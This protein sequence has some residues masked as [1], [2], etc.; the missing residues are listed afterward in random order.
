MQVAEP[1]TRGFLKR[2]S[3]AP[4]GQKKKA[5]SA[6]RRPPFADQPHPPLHHRPPS[7]PAPPM[8]VFVLAVA[9]LAAALWLG[10]V[11][12]VRLTSLARTPL[13]P[14]YDYIVSQA[15]LSATPCQRLVQGSSYMP[16]F[17][18]LQGLW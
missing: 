14:R 12:Y 17:V 4:S 2:W 16:G 3:D 5:R 1:C 13:A 15:G 11:L 8:L 18:C 6:W 7:Q 9:G 10:R